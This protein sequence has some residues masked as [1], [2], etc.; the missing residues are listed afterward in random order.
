MN[1]SPS[2]AIARD[3][4]EF[5]T[6]QSL[7]SVISSAL[8]I[9]PSKIADNLA[10]QDIAEW[11]SMGH[12]KLML[13]IEQ[14]YSTKISNRQVLQLTSVA[15]LRAFVD[16]LGGA[17]PLVRR[18]PATKPDQAAPA[19]NRGL[20]GIYFDRSAITEIDPFGSGLR[21]RGYD[22]DDL[23][24]GASYEETVFLLITGRLPDHHEREAFSDK[25]RQR[26]E[27][28]PAVVALLG[29]MSAAPPFL[30]LQA[31]LAALGAF[32]EDDV[33]ADISVIAQVPSLL[34]SFHR[35]RTGCQP[36]PPR[37]DLGH[38]ANLLYQIHGE[39]PAHSHAAALD[40]VLVLLADHSSSASTFAA[41]LVT[42]TNAG[43]HA[44]L[45]SAVA[46]FSGPLHGGAVN[47]VIAMA[48]QIGA[49]EA[50]A[51]FIQDRLARKETIYGFGHRIYRAADPRSRLLRSIAHRL[52]QERND[53]RTID[54]LEAVAA[55]LTDY[56][57]LGLDINVDFYASAA[58][59]ALRIPEDLFGPVFAAARMAG[60]V[61]H[62]REQRSN[63]VLIRPQLFYDGAPERKYKAG[64]AP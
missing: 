35:L 14:A 29:S 56:S 61:A 33:D 12:V 27:I 42:S 51:A 31:A 59:E 5:E 9:A 46:A 40:E 24:G 55:A 53:T 28:P 58:F 11:D 8:R 7:E 49:P 19:I 1:T 37:D 44:A 62:V 20:V 23:A 6:S 39:A 25:L 4:P 47:E 17:L 36:L 57:R 63:N 41:R 32:A 48:K 45:S 10:Y 38:A 60:L 26:R 54:I 52:C 16:Q 2:V 64:I 34:G 21:Y 22:V 13:A 30:A 50:A 3:E 18:D 15:S 43:L